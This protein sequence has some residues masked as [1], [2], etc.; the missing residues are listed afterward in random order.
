MVGIQEK[1]CNP[2]SKLEGNGISAADIKKLIEAGF[3]TVESVAFQP[4]KLLLNVKGISEVKADKLM[5]EC[6]HIFSFIGV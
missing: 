5:A 6:V 2:I 4:K 3:H 1:A